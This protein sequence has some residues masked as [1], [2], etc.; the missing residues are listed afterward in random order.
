MVKTISIIGFVL[1]AVAFNANAQDI[2]RTDRL[3]KEV[4]EINIRLSRLESLLSSPS[5]VQ[6]HVTSDKGWK[7]VMNW[8]K[9]TTD[10]D[11][12]D[13]KKIL[14]EPYQVDGGQIAHWYYQNGGNVTFMHG[15]VFEWREPRY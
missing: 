3:E 9:I 12:S 1:F 10:M 11:Y 5:K 15:K 13:V 4:Q 2:D 7:S 14:G 6:E 8:R